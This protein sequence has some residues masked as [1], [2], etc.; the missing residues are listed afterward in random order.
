M[1]GELCWCSLLLSLDSFVRMMSSLDDRMRVGSSPGEGPT[2]P[3]T[4]WHPARPKRQ[5]VGFQHVKMG[6]LLY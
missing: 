3:E 1:S 4:F 2:S 6:P 5:G